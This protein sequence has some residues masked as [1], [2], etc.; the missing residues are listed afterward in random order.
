LR[1][2]AGTGRAVAAIAKAPLSPSC[3]YCQVAAIAELSAAPF[4]Q[5]RLVVK[6]AE[7]I[8]KGVTRCN[9]YF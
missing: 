1:R 3:R 4:P 6:M 7:D 5:A 9:E 2:Q 8:V